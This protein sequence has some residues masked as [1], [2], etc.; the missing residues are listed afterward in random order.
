MSPQERIKRHL[1]QL[2]GIASWPDD[3]CKE[4]MVK[5]VEAKIKKLKLEIV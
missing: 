3:E 2:E 5:W 4:S 1:L